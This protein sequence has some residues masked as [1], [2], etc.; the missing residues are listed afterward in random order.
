MLSE[1]KLGYWGLTALVFGLMVGLG[2]FNLPQNMGA[3][4]NPGAVF[5]GWTVTAAG[6]LPLVLSFKWLCDTFPQYNGG[7][8]RYAQTGFGDYIGFNIAWG[9]WLCSAFSN[10][11][12]GIMLNDACGAIW[13]ELLAHRWPTVIFCSVFIWIMYF[14]VCSGIR[15]AKF[16]NTFLAVIKGISLLLIIS[17]LVIFFKEDLFRYEIWSSSQG[18]GGIDNQVKSIMMITLFCFF[19]VEG[20]VMMSHRAKNSKDIGKASISGFTLAFILYMAVALLCYGILARSDLETLPNPSIAYLLKST[21]G[22]W[23]YWF[24]IW[25]IIISLTGG[26]VSWTLLVAQVPLEASQAGIMPR[27]FQK[28]N[29]HH[30]PSKGLFASSIAMELF[31]LVVVLSPD[32]YTTSLNITGL[33]IIP[34]Y[35]FTA[36][37]VLKKANTF[38]IRITG[39]SAALFCLWMAYAGGLTNL[40]MTSVFYLA[41]I[42]FYIQARKEQGSDTNSCFNTGERFI[43]LAIVLFSIFSLYLLTR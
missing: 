22:P 28:L 6:M 38:K 43:L 18:I 3:S 16:V 14:I 34:C 21:C 39:I 7:L 2:I 19:G 9:Y 13:P 5:I 4:A 11:A 15:T 36:L 37:F 31:L 35:F 40:L 8:Y 20:A 33:M 10:V 29:K 23:A 42:L 17:V 26:W 12:Y 27:M 41:G 25:A 30:M 24:V 32:A 1:G